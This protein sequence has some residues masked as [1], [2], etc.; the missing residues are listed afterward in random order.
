MLLSINEIEFAARKAAA[1]AGWPLGL[2]EEIGRAV[3]WSAMQDSELVGPVLDLVED[4]FRPTSC[5]Q[6]D[7]L[8]MFGEATI[9]ATVSACDLLVGGI[10]RQAVLSDATR[11]LGLAAI[12]GTVASVHGVRFRM[13]AGEAVAEISPGG[14]RRS[15]SLVP[16]ADVS[17]VINGTCNPDHSRP[18]DGLS[19]PAHDWERLQILA[20]KSLVP[21]TMKSRETGAGAGIDDS[22]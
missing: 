4:G 14:I 16:P 8:A 1:G 18:T 20:K 10:C 3:I 2:A 9:T 13:Q 17:I 12:A 7:G 6:R 19:L 15:G 5:H 21:A 22:D 11:P